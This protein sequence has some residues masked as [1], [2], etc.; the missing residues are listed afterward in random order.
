MPVSQSAPLHRR[1]QVAGRT[2][3]QDLHDRLSLH[4]HR[5]G[6]QCGGNSS[7]GPL[8]SQHLRQA[9]ALS[10]AFR[11]DVRTS[12]RCHE[13]VGGV[14]MSGVWHVDHE[15]RVGGL[16]PRARFGII[17]MRPENAAAAPSTLPTAATNA[18]SRR[19]TRRALSVACGVAASAQTLMRHR[20]HASFLTESDSGGLI[21]GVY[22]YL[23]GSTHSGVVNVRRA[24][25]TLDQPSWTTERPMAFAVQRER[26]P[27]RRRARCPV[28]WA[29]RSPAADCSAGADHGRHPLPVAGMSQL[30]RAASLETEHCHCGCRR[31]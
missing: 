6:C 14:G 30:V 12:T 10:A 27:R 23:A 28:G 1:T 24:C 22:S 3:G 20:R 13:Q 4:H 2:I 5:L 19:V 8:E 15:S 18:R 21:H 31:G 7:T 25:Q 17:E 16:I 26:A 11:V 9:S 29:R